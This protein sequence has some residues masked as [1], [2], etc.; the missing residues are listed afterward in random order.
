MSL[1]TNLVSYRKFDE[2]SW[3][4]AFD[5]VG[6]NDLS[7]INWPTWTTWKKENAI[8]FGGVDDRAWL[9]NSIITWWNFSYNL[10]VYSYS[11]PFGTIISDYYKPLNCNRWPVVAVLGGTYRLWLNNG[12]TSWCSGSLIQLNSWTQPNINSWDMLSLTYNSWNAK[13]YIN[14]IEKASWNHTPFIWHSGQ[15]FT[16]GARWNSWSSVYDWN[17]NWK[18]DEVWIWN[19]ALTQAEVTELYNWWAGLQYPFWVWGKKNNIFMY[20]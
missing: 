14:W 12:G 7:L 17:F 6:S 19:K 3:T 13:I 5:S 18:I 9:N 1:T 10:W 2:N 11:E 15:R 8:D 16:I 4:T 20:W